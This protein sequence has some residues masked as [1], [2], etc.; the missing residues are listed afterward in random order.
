M[1]M[2]RREFL[3][4]GAGLLAGAAVATIGAGNGTA[5][6]AKSEETVD[7]GLAEAF[8]EDGVYDRFR[9][10]GFLL[11]RKGERLIALSSLCTHRA[12]QLKIAPDKSFI[13]PCHGSTFDP[14]GV[15]TKG[16]AERNLPQLP[17]RIDGAGRL[18]VEVPG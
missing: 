8:L 6:A 11:I 12:C 15:L 9:Y 1:T 18:H 17:I 13:C 5:Y 3:I 2:N 4:G 10:Q 14:E 16:P 7:A